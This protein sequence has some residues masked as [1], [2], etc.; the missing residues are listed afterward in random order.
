MFGFDG[1]RLAA[2]RGG[3]LL[4]LGDPDEAGLALAEAL[5]ALS[6]GCVRRRAEVMLDLA[7]VRLARGDAEEAG[8]LAADAVDGFAA[9]GS[10]SGLRRAARFAVALAEAGQVAAA[11]SV[12]E[13][14]LSHSS[15]P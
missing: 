12:Q 5:A 4:R 7:G 2:Y 3:C 1:A 13:Q 9:R 11:L 10:G 6:P 8:R 15:P 14:I